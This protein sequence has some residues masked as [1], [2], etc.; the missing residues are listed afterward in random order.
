[1]NERIFTPRFI[2]ITFTILIA[3][4]MRLLPHPP[5]FAPIAAIALLGGACY[6]DK[7]M[8]FIIPFAAMLISDVLIG[9]H[10]TMWA[11][12]LSFGITV[13]AG[14]TLRN[15]FKVSSLIIASLA[16]SILFFLI[17]NFAVWFGSA[18]YTQDIKGLVACYISAVPFYENNLF[19]SFFLNT[20]L[21]DL[22]YTGLL[23]GALYIAQLR[24][25]KLDLIRIR[26]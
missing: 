21:G 24:F 14:F 16:S 8:A 10:D 23:F 20:I 19:G 12:Y 9:F 18:F 25:P 17:T 2:L 22:F 1:M 15:N 4:L 3:A 5:N 6:S 7:K 13:V 11:V 26:K